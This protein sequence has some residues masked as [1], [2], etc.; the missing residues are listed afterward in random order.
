VRFS[1]TDKLVIRVAV[2]NGEKINL[3]G[4]FPDGTTVTELYTGQTATVENGTVT[5]QN[6]QHRL[7]VIK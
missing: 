4:A 5:F 1:D 3:G 6:L 2:D 7:A